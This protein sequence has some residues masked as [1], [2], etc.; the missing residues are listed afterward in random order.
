[1]Q[2]YAPREYIRGKSKW[3][4]R[5]SQFDHMGSG[6]VIARKQRKWHPDVVLM[7]W[8][9]KLWSMEQSH[10]HGWAHGTQ[11]L[12]PREC[13][14][15]KTSETE[16]PAT[17][18]HGQWLCCYEMASSDSEARQLLCLWA[19]FCLAL[20]IPQVWARQGFGPSLHFELSFLHP[21]KSLSL[22]K[23]RKRDQHLRWWWQ[24]L[25]SKVP[26]T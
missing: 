25:E 9:S 17:W 16:G 26:W 8:D 10:L 24:L 22:R 5:D 14:K 3:S 18:K 2:T 15:S 21:E 4:R 23:V 20:C 11:P 13:N 12:V 19:S 1:M 7:W 6:D